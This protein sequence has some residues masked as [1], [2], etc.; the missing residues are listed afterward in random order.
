MQDA[1]VVVVVLSRHGYLFGEFGTSRSGDK[2]DRVFGSH[3][4]DL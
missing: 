2:S 4:A 1:T 3:V